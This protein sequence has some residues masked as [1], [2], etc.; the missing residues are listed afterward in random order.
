MELRKKNYF[1]QTIIYIIAIVFSLFCLL[2]FVMVVS[3][4][5][6]SEQEIM[7]YGYSIIPKKLTTLAYKVLFSKPDIIINAYLISTI[8]TVIGTTL[9]RK[10][11]LL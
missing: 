6:T 4:S 2:P 5:L 8:V 10:Y 11:S 3:G 9:D 7:K 1:N